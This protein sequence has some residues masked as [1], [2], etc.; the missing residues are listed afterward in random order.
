MAADRPRPGALADRPAGPRIARTVREPSGRSLGSRQRGAG[1]PSGRR[2]CRPAALP[3]SAGRPRRGPAGPGPEDGRPRLAGHRARPPVTAARCRPDA[4]NHSVPG[5]GHPIGGRAPPRVPPTQER[6]RRLGGQPSG[7]R[8]R[9]DVRPRHRVRTRSASRWRSTVGPSTR[10]PAPSRT[11]G[12]ARTTWWQRGGRS[13]GSPG[14]TSSIAPLTSCVG[15]A[16]SWQNDQREPR[17]PAEQRLAGSGRWCPP[18]ANPCPDPADGG[19]G[20][21]S[22]PQAGG[23]GVGVTVWGVSV[24]GTCGRSYSAV[25]A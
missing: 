8:R 6:D 14:R 22:G 10:I 12:P 18:G 13:C 7:P 4:P 16:G 2:R 19:G 24:C 21:A 5:G 20:A 17:A 3:T 9:P 25:R 15:S 23:D 1:G 11:T